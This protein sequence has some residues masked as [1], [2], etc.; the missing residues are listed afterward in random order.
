MSRLNHRTAWVVER[1]YLTQWTS[2]TVIKFVHLQKNSIPHKCI[3]RT[4]IAIN[5]IKLCTSQCHS[6]A[7][8][9]NKWFQKFKKLTGFCRLSFVFISTINLY[10]QLRMPITVKPTHNYVDC[11]TIFF[12]IFNYQ[13]NLFRIPSILK[14]HGLKQ[15]MY[16]QK[17]NIALYRMI[18]LV[19]NSTTELHFGHLFF[20][21]K[22]FHGE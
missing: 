7:Q 17:K 15:N 3:G 18:T 14:V 19:M 6:C 8:S 21:G 1:K 9:C 10:H 11:I 12:Y 5:I 2:D 22:K 4:A 16:V 13:M 20:V